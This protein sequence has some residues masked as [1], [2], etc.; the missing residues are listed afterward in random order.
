M[1]LNCEERPH[2]LKLKLKLRSLEGQDFMTTG[3][4]H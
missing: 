1:I 3:Y 2:K 4:M